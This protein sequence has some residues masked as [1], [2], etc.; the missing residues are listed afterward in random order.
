[1]ILPKTIRSEAEIDAGLPDIR[2]GTERAILSRILYETAGRTDAENGAP[3]LEQDRV[4]DTYSPNAPGQKKMKMRTAMMVGVGFAAL[5]LNSCGQKPAPAETIPA[6]E[7]DAAAQS[8][9][10]GAPQAMRVTRIAQRDLNDVISGTG[11]LVVR[12]EAAV[13]TELSGYRVEK[14][15]V[16]EGDWVKAGQPLAKMD[17]TL[18]K[19]QIAQAEA[20]LAQQKAS[21]DFNDANLKR[22]E[23]LAA[24]GAS[25]QQAL[26]QARMQAA[27]SDAAL[28]AAQASLNEMKTRDERMVLRAPVTGR[29]LQRAIRP[30]DISSPATATPYFRIARDGL[31]ELDAELTDANLSQIKEGDPVHVT[32]SSGQ[33]L[34]GK[35]RFISPRVDAS[36]SLGKARIELPY[37]PALRA[38]GFATAKFDGKDKG[39]LTVLA[40]AVRYE[41][42]GPAL[43]VVGKGNQV[44]QTPVKLGSRIGDYVELVDGP[45]AGTMV[46]ETG[47][48]FTLDGDVIRPIEEEASAAG[49]AGSKPQ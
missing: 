39:G 8:S 15:Y 27:S 25:S 35:V 20:A 23:N 2:S 5:A 7:A 43:M 44:K 10:A 29:I 12:E 46:L 30:G 45:P 22:T 42:G 36:T 16:D 31:I 4:S 11:R 32:L 28:L 48:A 9:E 21:A 47:S 49:A 24:A 41:S 34:P 1:M 37:D 14:V 40:S 13:G 19:A 26:D 18:L 38:G 6:A 3:A 17:D 33:V